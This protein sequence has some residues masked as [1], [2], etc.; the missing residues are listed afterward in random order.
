MGNNKKSEVVQLIEFLEKEGFREIKPEERNK[1]E[2]RSSIEATRKL[3]KKLNPG[4][5]VKI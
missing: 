4:K 3:I 2:F 5:V 1:P